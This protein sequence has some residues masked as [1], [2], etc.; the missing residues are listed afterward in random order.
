[1]NEQECTIKEAWDGVNLKFTFRRT[2][3]VRVMNLWHELVQI[4][5]SISFNEEE[6]AIVWQYNSSGKY[7]VQSLYAI[8]NDRGMRQIF[9]RSCGRSMCHLG[10]IFSYGLVANNKTLTRDNLAKRRSVDDLTCL[11]CT[12]LETT[13]HLFFDCCVARVMWETISEVM[14]VAIQPDFES[15]AKWWLKDKKCQCI[16]I[17]TSAV[18]WSLWKTRNALCFQGGCWLVMPGILQRCA[19]YLRSWGV[20]IK[21]EEAR[22]CPSG[23]KNWKPEA[24][25][26]RC[27]HGEI[28]HT[29]QLRIHRPVINQLREMC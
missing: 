20:L 17:C 16:N 2:V 19:R 7:S 3:N 10:F 9:T 4:A 15:M 18:L 5:S 27:F 14:G 22:H 28:R 11:F 8:V 29:Q 24:E 12:E 13:H 1:V 21:E 23:R 26:H 6:D 25:G